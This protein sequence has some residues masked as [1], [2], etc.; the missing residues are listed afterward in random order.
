[1]SDSDVTKLQN[2]NRRSF[3][4]RV[5]TTVLPTVWMIGLIILL[6]AVQYAHAGSTTP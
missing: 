3:S 6:A 5:I 4:S 1:M 2:D